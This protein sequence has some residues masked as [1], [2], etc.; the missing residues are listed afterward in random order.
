MPADTS[1][2]NSSLIDPSRDMI[3][4]FLRKRGRTPRSLVAAAS[5]FQ[6]KTLE[7]G[8][9]ADSLLKEAFENGGDDPFAIVAGLYLRS[10]D[11]DVSVVK[12]LK[13]WIL[14]DGSN[15]FPKFLLAVQFAYSKDEKAMYEAL[16]E[17]AD[18]P[19]SHY[20]DVYKKLAEEISEFFV[21]NHA[22]DGD[23]SQVYSWERGIGYLPNA[24]LSGLIKE[25]IR[26]AMARGDNQTAAHSAALGISAALTIQ[27]SPSLL[28][29]EWG[30]LCEQ[31]LLRRLQESGRVSDFIP[32]YGNYAAEQKNQLETLNRATIIKNSPGFLKALDPMV[33]QEFDHIIA[34]SGEADAYLFLAKSL[35]PENIPRRVGLITPPRAQ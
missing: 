4:G 6:R 16:T 2:G 33:R 29:R 14:R 10:K 5:L 8:K 20:Q 7:D 3:E 32:D 11:N 15:G 25:Q 26:E 31:T 21:D 35:P 9:Y 27:Q 19:G 1:G 18:S 23:A 22:S 17:L 13:D 12:R 30:L 28:M 34:A 24:S